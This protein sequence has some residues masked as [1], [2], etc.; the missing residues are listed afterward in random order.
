MAGPREFLT[1]SDLGLERA[2]GQ[3]CWGVEYDRYF[4]LS[5]YIGNPRLDVREPFESTSPN[6]ASRRFAAHRDVRP[7]GEWRLWLRVAR[8]SIREGGQTLATISSS[9]RQKRGAMSDLEGQK[10]V[11]LRVDVRTGA[12]C[13][14]FDL[15]GVLDVRRFNRGDDDH[16][17]DL[18]KPSGYVLSVRGDGTYDHEPASE[19]DRR[20]R[21][22]RRP[23]TDLLKR[24][25]K[26]R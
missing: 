17:W 6:K 13:F 10:L 24:R 14:T 18:W 15:G 8:W 20:P 4:N 16:L 5:M 23:L 12:S 21:L 7:R 2:R 11:D 9:L 3:Y 19:L 25:R 22:E 1:L 26:R